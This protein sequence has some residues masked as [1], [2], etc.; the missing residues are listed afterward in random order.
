MANSLL[1]AAM[2]YAGI[3]WLVLPLHNPVDGACSCGRACP[4]P[5]KHPR[6]LHGLQDA[7]IDEATIAKWWRRWPEANIGVATG[8]QSGIIV[9][10]VD[11]LMSLRHL[12]AFHGHLPETASAITG[13]GKHLYFVHPID[14]LSNSVNRLGPGLDIRGDGGYCVSPPSKHISGAVYRWISAKGIGP[15][16]CPKWLLEALMAPV[17][18]SATNGHEGAIANGQRNDILFR[19]ACAMRA[20]GASP[21]AILAALEADNA[22]RCQPPLDLKE[23]Q[24]IAKSAAR[25]E[26]ASPRDTHPLSEKQKAIQTLARRAR[27]I[28][29]VS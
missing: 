23:V 14:H 16:P 20:W 1:Q 25:Y 22:E 5:A 19:L 3:G 27:R 11:N 26:A 2:Q 29:Y 10:D 7:T 21:R 4:S 8:A 9:L 13:K 17:P 28:R 6:T 24:Q 12:E 18:P 15:A